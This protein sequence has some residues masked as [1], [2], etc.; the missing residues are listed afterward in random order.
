MS[1][2]GDP[3]RSVDARKGGLRANKVML[4]LHS[5]CGVRE[6]IYRPGQRQAKR[7]REILHSVSE[8]TCSQI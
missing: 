6:R 1:K 4:M 2:E 3:R 8:Y 7:G 5:C